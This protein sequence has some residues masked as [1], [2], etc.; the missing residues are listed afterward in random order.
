R[1]P[2]EWHGDD[3]DVGFGEDAAE[4]VHAHQAV[5]SEL[6]GVVRPGCTGRRHDAHAEDPRT[7]GNLTTDAPEPD[8]AECASRE[9]PLGPPGTIAPVE[10]PEP[11]IHVQQVA[12]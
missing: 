6:G 3:Q 9:I 5:D 8:G 2:V 1:V 11:P 7:P 12:V 4:S 10:L